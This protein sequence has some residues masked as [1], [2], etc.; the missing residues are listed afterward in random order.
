MP[1]A[2]N[3]ELNHIGISMKSRKTGLSK[4]EW[5]HLEILHVKKPD[6]RNAT[7]QKRLPKGQ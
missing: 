7:V 4:V 3:T 1:C 5:N 6:S 2:L